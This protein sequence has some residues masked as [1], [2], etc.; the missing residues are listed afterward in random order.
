MNFVSQVDALIISDLPAECKEPDLLVLAQ[1]YGRVKSCEIKRDFRNHVISMCGIISYYSHESAENAFRALNGAKYMGKALRSVRYLLDFSCFADIL[2]RVNWMPRNLPT[3][4]NP[5]IPQAPKNLRTAQVH[6][7]YLSKQLNFIISEQFLRDVFSN[8]GTVLE[9][10]LKKTCVDPVRNFQ[11][12]INVIFL[13]F[14]RKC[15]FKMVT[16]LFIIL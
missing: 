16:A 3:N 14:R 8:F 9:I 13:F 10:A 6:I 2:L 4:Q 7:S 5:S 1:T 12:V 15:L 11:F